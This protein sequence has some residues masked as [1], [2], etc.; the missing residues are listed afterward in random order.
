[1]KK[2][3]YSTVA[4]Y[5][6]R[7]IWTAVLRRS[8]EYRLEPGGKIFALAGDHYEYHASA[9]YDR[10]LA[11]DALLGLDAIDLSPVGAY[12]LVMES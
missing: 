10:R 12:R 5:S 7:E 11:I 4:R 1:M 2:L 6:S 9:D 3:K 8:D